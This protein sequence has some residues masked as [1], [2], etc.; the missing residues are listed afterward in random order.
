MESVIIERNDL[1]HDVIY[2]IS[3]KAQDIKFPIQRVVNYLLKEGYILN[4]T[5]STKT[6]YT[7]FKDNKK[8]VVT[9]NFISFETLEQGD[10]ERYKQNFYTY[11]ISRS[12]IY[13]QSA[14]QNTKAAKINLIQNQRRTCVSNMYYSLHNSFA[15]MVEF[16]KTEML[17]NEHLLDEESSNEDETKLEHFVPRGLEVLVNNIDDIL[18]AE[19]EEYISNSKMDSGR[20]KSFENPFSW[21]FPLFVDLMEDK[22]FI[23]IVNSMSDALQNVNLENY[24][25]DNTFRRSGFENQLKENLIK[26][27]ELSQDG[28]II[29]KKALYLNLAGFLAYAY[30]LRQS[31]DYDSLFEIKIPHRDIINWTIITSNFLDFVTNFVRENNTQN[32][33]RIQKL[34]AESSTEILQTL[35]TDSRSTI[36]TMTGIIIDKEFEL[37]QVIKK[38]YS[39]KGYKMINQRGRII[40]LN[41]NTETI[42]ICRILFG[43]PL[44]CF[45]SFSTQGLFRIDIVLNEEN[46]NTEFSKGVNQF[47]LEQLIQKIII[48][49]DLL[50]V[51]SNNANIVRGIPTTMQYNSLNYL[52]LV[53]GI[54]E[55]MRRSIQFSL[56]RY[57]REISLKYS[58]ESFLVNCFFS[59][60]RNEREY[61]YKI[62]NIFDGYQLKRD[63]IPNIEQGVSTKFLIIYFSPYSLQNS[64]EFET[65]ATKYIK[66]LYPE[67]D[68]KVELLTMSELEVE[69]VIEKDYSSLDIII[70]N[71]KDKFQKV[72]SIGENPIINIENLNSVEYEI[73]EEDIDDIVED[74][75]ETDK[76][77]VERKIGQE[78]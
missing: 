49:K 16:Y 53:I 42:S 63:V 72:Q 69:Q 77:K 44:E 2:E 78:S 66:D 21:I 54:H 5:E 59:M 57:F 67:L 18:T 33:N 56:G 28:E 58:T 40:E 76:E 70:E 20:T 31:A 46:E 15:S 48:E 65:F 41:E 22:K 1:L 29:D 10:R 61:K 47:Y 45:I 50:T 25:V 73:N 55:Q 13:Y 38:L 75:R 35:D 39:Q 51:V 23:E 6:A 64:L 24:G 37:V 43:T 4:K 26:I 7:L 60:K 52:D 36:M 68:C 32:N 14:V 71:L 34:D 62:R 17:V 11:V 19:K 74:I 8:T 9:N 3:Q 12:K 30:M 27:R